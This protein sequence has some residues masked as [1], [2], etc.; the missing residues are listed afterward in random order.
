MPHVELLD[1]TLRDGQQS[2]WGMR[3]QAGMALPVAG[4]LFRIGHLGDLNE[5]MLLGALA[6]AEMAMK[7]SGIDV[8]SDQVLRRHRSIGEKQR[9]S[10]SH[11]HRRRAHPTRRV[12]QR[13][14]RQLNPRPRRRRD[15]PHAIRAR[16]PAAAPQRARGARLAS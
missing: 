9:P 5:L 1:E 12:R 13:S 10:W 14:V 8:S 3:M 16:A 2:L 6:G 11:R 15:E 4:K 7:D